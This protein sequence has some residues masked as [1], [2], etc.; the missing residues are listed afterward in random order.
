MIVMQ[1]SFSNEKGIEH[2]LHTTIANNKLVKQTKTRVYSC[3]LSKRFA[4]H[5]KAFIVV[6]TDFSIF[7][8]FSLGVL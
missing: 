7:L 8:I 6:Y 5:D 4:N 3:E 1:I 2:V